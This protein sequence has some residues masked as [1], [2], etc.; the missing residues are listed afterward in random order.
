MSDIDDTFTD[1]V[2]VQPAQS[3][4]DTE[5]AVT[6][7]WFP[8]G[9]PVP[10][11]EY[12]IRGGICWPVPTPDGGVKAFAVVVGRHLPTKT[13]YWLGETQWRSIEHIVEDGAVTYEGV[14][15]W[16]AEVW[17]AFHFVQWYY[18]G[19]REGA[20]RHIMQINDSANIEPK[21]CFADVEWAD[22]SHAVGLMRMLGST[23]KLAIP[24][25]SAIYLAEQGWSVLPPDAKLPPE[26]R[27]FLAALVGMELYPWCE[28]I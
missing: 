28:V 10:S 5:R 13:Y 12:D 22:H 26:L 25:T 15:P 9:S 17:S 4:R 8:A 11:G 14:F 23:G 19:D 1:P 16:L 3:I 21:P 18:A 24:H 7:L 20:W 27:A 2:H 6:R